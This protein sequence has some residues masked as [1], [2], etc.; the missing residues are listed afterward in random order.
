VKNK[1]GVEPKMRRTATTCIGK[2]L[3]TDKQLVSLARANDRDAFGELIR[4]HHPACLRLA[5]YM[6]RNR[7]EAEE[8]VQNAY[9][10]AYEHLDQFQ[11]AAEFSSWLSRIVTNH[12]LMLMRVK[13]RARMVYIDGTQSRDGDGVIEL[14]SVTT[15]PERDLIQNQMAYVLQREIKRI[16]AL[17]R[18]VVVLRDVEQLP[19][20]TVARRLGIT[21]PAA[22]SRLFRA[23]V[24]LRSRVQQHCGSSGYTVPRS[25]VQSMPAKSARCPV[26][27]A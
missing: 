5:I 6:L 27:A 21:V 7:G 13:A 8:E 3:L 26:A 15:D 18:N 1:V 19:M 17:L 14:Q 16:P 25:S 12:C 23:R 10:R 24:E 20:P 4:R 9:M 22:K 11:G 2:T